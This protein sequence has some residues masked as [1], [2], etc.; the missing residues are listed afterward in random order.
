MFG[1]GHFKPNEDCVLSSVAGIGPVAGPN[2]PLDS[3]ESDTEGCPPK[4]PDNELLS[5]SSSVKSESVEGN[6]EVNP[7]TW[8]NKT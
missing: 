8:N 6:N 2:K 5:D 4:R 1:S 7:L 3:D